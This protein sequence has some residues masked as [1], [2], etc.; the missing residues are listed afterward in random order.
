MCVYIFFYLVNNAWLF[1]KNADSQD[2]HRPMAN[3]DDATCGFASKG[4]GGGHRGTGTGRPVRVSNMTLPLAKAPGGCLGLAPHGVDHH[5][6]SIMVVGPRH[7]RPASTPSFY[8]SL[9]R[10]QR[11]PVDSSISL[12]RRGGRVQHSGA[13]T[14]SALSVTRAKTPTG[15]KRR[16]RRLN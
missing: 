1:V 7:T 10:H 5:A 14:P 15:C 9:L 4:S 6:N 8:T 2:R 13:R 11:V 3:A 12:S 16:R